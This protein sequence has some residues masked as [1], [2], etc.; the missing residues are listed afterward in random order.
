MKIKLNQSSAGPNGNTP[1]G[2]IIDTDSATGEYLINSRQ[3]ILMSDDDVTQTTT[4]NAPIE[5]SDAHI[6]QETTAGPGR[7]GRPPKKDE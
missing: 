4:V 3:G 5:T 6:E 7:R 2:T 1:A